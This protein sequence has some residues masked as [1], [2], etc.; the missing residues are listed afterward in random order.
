MTAYESYVVREAGEFIWDGFCNPAGVGVRL[1]EI[2]DGA[3]L[4]GVDLTNE[5][6]NGVLAHA[7]EPDKWTDGDESTRDAIADAT[8]NADYNQMKAWLS[9]IVGDSTAAG[10]VREWEEEAA[11][12]V[13]KFDR[14]N[15]CFIQTAKAWKDTFAD[16]LK[17]TSDPDERNAIE[18]AAALLDDVDDSDLAISYVASDPMDFIILPYGATTREEQRLV[19]ALNW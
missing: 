13:E 16:E 17:E 19:R 14:E 11:S 10:L 2:L 6:K 5:Q 9:Y 18:A 1:Q 7:D 8:D 3:S 12:I 15:D 4:V